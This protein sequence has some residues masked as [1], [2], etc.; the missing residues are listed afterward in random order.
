MARAGTGASR[1]PMSCPARHSTS[2]WSSPNA[3][4]WP[5]RGCRSRETRQRNGWPSPKRSPAPP[6][7][8]GG[9]GSSLSPARRSQVSDQLEHLGSRVAERGTE[10]C[11]ARRD[12]V[13]EADQ[14]FVVDRFH[15]AL[16]LA[17]VRFQR[18]ELAGEVR[19]VVTAY[20]FDVVPAR[21]PP[22]KN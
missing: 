1:D 5:T 3:G 20:D 9:Q 12:A 6:A 2:A 7:R 13:A 10:A 16:E 11:Q 15:G 4:T 19:A 22:N 14:L 21:P 8:V 17:G 18:I